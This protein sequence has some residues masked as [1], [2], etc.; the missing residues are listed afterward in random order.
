MKK[1]IFIAILAMATTS[2]SA[3]KFGVKAGLN[4][5]THLGDDADGA[6]VQPGFHIGG[7]VELPLSKSLY[8]QPELLLSQKGAKYKDGGVTSRMK[9]LYLEVPV[10]LMLKADLVTGKVTIAAGPYFAY[11]VSGKQSSGGASVDLFSKADGADEAIL[12]R[13]DAGIGVA[14]GYEFNSG[15]F[16]NL[17]TSYGLTNVAEEAGVSVKNSTVT[18][19]VGYKF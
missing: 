4:L 15:L 1:L 6:K 11:G 7:V 9:P 18:L 19:S 17:G 8:L 3:Q 12:K 10:N 13:F 16:F 14:A 2:I 5:S